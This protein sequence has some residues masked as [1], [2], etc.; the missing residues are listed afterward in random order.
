VL[1]AGARTRKAL[2]AWGWNLFLW[3]QAAKDN[4]RSQRSQNGAFSLTMK[5]SKNA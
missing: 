1:T 2:G 3:P 4:F 5:I